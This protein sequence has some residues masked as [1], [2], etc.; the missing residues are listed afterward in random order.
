MTGKAVV[1]HYEVSGSGQPIVFVHGGF[2]SLSDWR[3]Q[4]ASLSDAWQV[5]AVDL[6]GHGRTPIDDVEA[7]SPEHC[8]AAVNEFVAAQAG[9]KC[10][11]AGHSFGTRVVLEAARQRPDQVAG[12]VLVDT[13]RVSAAGSE[14][15]AGAISAGLNRLGAARFIEEYFEAMMVGEKSPEIKADLIAARLGTVDERMIRA[16]ML[17]TVRWDS[18]RMDEALDAVAEIDVLAIQSTTNHLGAPRQPVHEAAEV[19]WLDLLS[20]RLPR[21]RTAIVPNAGHFCMLEKPDLVS[22]AID[23]F[24]RTVYQVIGPGSR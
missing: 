10:V 18:E 6:P 23:R 3:F 4:S 1:M 5:F 20:R 12:I 7:I 22:D 14:A 19:P 15:D 2:C 17:S 9:G 21:L 11:L 24:A 16:I 13:S 8:A